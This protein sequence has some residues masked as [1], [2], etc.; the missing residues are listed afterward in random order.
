MAFRDARL[1][2][3]ERRLG[4]EMPRRPYP[5]VERLR[6]E[7]KSWR[8][9]SAAMQWTLSRCRT[10]LDASYREKT[11][12][13]AAALETE[14]NLRKII[15]HEDLWML[16]AVLDEDRLLSDESRNPVDEDRVAA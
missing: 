7:D 6:R 16:K 3:M 1:E 9:I 11:R 8:D 4:E 12:A 15:G 13:A 2:V 14:R 5:L 10:G